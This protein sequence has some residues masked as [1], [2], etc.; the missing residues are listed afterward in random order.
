MFEDC[1]R[2]G[3]AP[4]ADEL[5]YCGHCQ[6]AIRAE[7]EDGFYQLRNYLSGWARFTEWCNAHG[8]AHI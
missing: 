1:I 7:I 2:C 4:A 3:D 6:W 5:G 8:L